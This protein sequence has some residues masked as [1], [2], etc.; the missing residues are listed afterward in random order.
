MELRFECPVITVAGTNGKGS[1][2]AM[3]EAI[4]CRPAGAPGVY[5]SPHLVHFEERCRIHGEI[6][7]AAELV[8]HFER[9]EAARGDVSLT[10]F[11]FTTLAIMSLLAAS[12]LDV[13]ILEVGLGGRLDAVNIIDAD[14]AV[15]TSIDLDHQDHPGRRPRK[16]RPREGRH[17][18]RRQARHRERPGAA[19]KRAGPCAADRRRSL[20]GR[21]RLQ[22]FRRQAAMGLGRARAALCGPGLPGAA[23]RQPAGERGGRAGGAGSIARPPARD[24]AGGAQRAGDGGTARA[25][26]RSCRASRCWCWTSRTT[27]I[28]WR[29]WRPISTRWASIPPRTPCSARWPTRT[30]RRCCAAWGRWWTAGTS[31][32][33]PRA[34]ADPPRACWTHGRPPGPA[35]DVRASIHAD[36]RAGAAKRG[37]RGG[38]R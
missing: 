28:R 35:Q 30:W 7:K 34:R 9:V 33:C 27:R 14:C 13:V 15:I 22:F 32:T 19:A 21:A 6:A 3:L 20:A 23:R 18:A 2:C 1:T 5:T 25:A 17:P 24:R 8:P 11:E 4:P 38:P 29:R 37:G 26:S 12:R 16:H 36:A 31:P 10:Y